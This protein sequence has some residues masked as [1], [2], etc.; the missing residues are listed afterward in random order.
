MIADFYHEPVMVK[1]IVDLLLVSKTGIYVDC[2]IGG[3]GHSYAILKETDAF[4]VGIDCDDEALRFAESRLKEFGSRKVLIKANFADLGKVLE[5]LNIKKVDG[6]LLDLGVS[7]RQLD[8]AERGF[9][10]NLQAPLDMRMDRNLELSAYDIVN[11]F[12]Q[13]EL[14]NIIRFYGEEK[15]AAKIARTISKKRQLSP[16]ETTTELAA[17]VASCMPVKAKRQKIHPATRTFQAIRIAVNKE[18][19]NIKL[20]INAAVDALKS[21]GRL[22]IISFHSLEDR[23]VKNEFRALAGECVCPKDMPFCVCQKEAKLE[24]VT[25]KAL[26]PTAEEIKANPR[27]RSAKLRVARR[28]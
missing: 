5:N 17:I 26:I 24:N 11:S 10:F 9:S 28:V 8:A 3:A 7:S 4:L 18:L 22:C 2:T 1:E 21:G 13:N 20:V 27:A 15:M 6:I 19:E 25:R 16:I 14:E 12:A 23:I